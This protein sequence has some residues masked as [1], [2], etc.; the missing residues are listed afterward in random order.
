MPTGLE[1]NFC[2]KNKQH[3][4]FPLHFPKTTLGLPLG[5]QWKF[6]FARG[7]TEPFKKKQEWLGFVLLLFSSHIA[8]S[9]QLTI[10]F[11]FDL[12]KNQLE[13]QQLC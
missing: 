11:S 10:F 8:E 13:L 6:S 3:G 7:V 12:F 2:K 4:A 1:L 9:L 5:S